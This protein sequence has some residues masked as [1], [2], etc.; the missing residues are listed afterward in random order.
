M[1]VGSINS[2]TLWVK[3]PERLGAF[4]CDVLG[5]TR[6][7]NGDE[8]AV[9]YGGQGAWLVL[10]QSQS[11]R[12]HVLGPQDRY[13]KIA[14][15]LSDL[16]HAQARLVAQG[17]AASAPRQFRDIGYLSHLDDPEGHAIEF[18]QHTFDGDTKTAQGDQEHPL[19]G[20]AQI[21][22]ITLRTADIDRDMA[23]C[24]EQLGMRYLSRQAVTDRG[25]DLYFYAF[26][27]DQLPKQ[28]VN[29]IRNRPW[30]W[31]RPYTVLEFQHR[32]ESDAILPKPEEAPVVQ[33]TTTSGE[34]VSLT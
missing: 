29:A 2:L 14:I 9:G 4:Y 15:T 32:L 11:T 23:V 22:L 24:V 33:M 20:G 5:M 18:I 10:R 6:R 28:D 26:T 1:S 7:E 30:L 3:N 25:F 34:Q 31:Q 8:V 19:G 17:H 12:S 21:G 13:W 16:D 27:D